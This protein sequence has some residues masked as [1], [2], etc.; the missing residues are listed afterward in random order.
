MTLLK[1][2]VLRELLLPFIL[3]FATLDFI[4]MA[5][6]LVRAANFIIGRGVP[7]SDTLYVLILALPDIIS[8]TVPTSGLTAVLIVYG[9][10]SQNNEIRAMKASGIHPSHVILPAFLVGLGVSFLMF[11]FNDQVATNASFLLRRTTKQMLIKHPKAIIEP[12]RFVN[13]SDTLKF[14]AKELRGN[15]L[16]DIVAY[17]IEESNKPVRT[18]IAERGEIVSKPANTEMQVRLFDG[19]V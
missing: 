2:Y 19:S 14:F 15:E 6:Y 11:V 4:F 12:G 7:L 5:G 17:E 8:Y 10:F 13:L 3:C 9:S 18:I 16:R 1:R